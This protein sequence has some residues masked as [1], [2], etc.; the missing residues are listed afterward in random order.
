MTDIHKHCP[1]CNTPIPLDELTCSPKCQKVLEDRQAK[2]KR[3]RIILSFVMVAF[4]L[5]FAYMVIFN[6]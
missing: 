4:V 5:V 2:V 3:S 6:N 1:I